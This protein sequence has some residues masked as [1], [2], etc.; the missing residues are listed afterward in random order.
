M[1]KK[2]KNKMML[3]LPL[4][5]PFSSAMAMQALDDSSLSATTGQDGINIGV[6]VGKVDFN[7]AALID[8]DGI[9]NT[10]L[11]K[12]YSKSAA[13]TVA[14][15]TNNP[16]SINFVGANASPTINTVIDVDAG[17]GKPFSNIGI[18]FGSQITGIKMSPFA[19]Y[20]A[21]TNSVS[22]LNSTKSIFSGATSL[23]DGVTKLLEVGSA[24]NNFEITFNNLKRPQMNVQLGNVPQSQMVVFSGA[25]QSICGTGTGCPIAVI[26]GDT[27]A[28]FDFQMTAAD[29]V[30]GF[31]L[32]GFYAG[33]NPTGV[34]MGNTGTSSK[35]NLA[36]NNVVLGN[37]GTSSANVFN[38]IANGSMGNFGAIGASVKDLK[39]SIRGF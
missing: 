36:L 33:V 28:K 29:S 17:G 25:I 39:V 10:I 2:Y 37:T 22:T 1:W 34:V 6:S 32:Q 26:S 31:N 38:G 12:D 18:T 15:T 23:N 24:S 30:N 14:G 3:V 21:S 5:L 13:L 19:V 20:L 16:V 7:Q 11:S 8:K 4:L 27:S 9:S 35:M